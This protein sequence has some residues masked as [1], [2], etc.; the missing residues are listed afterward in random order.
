MS[1]TSSWVG[2]PHD[3]DVAIVGG[4]FAGTCAAATLS[5]LGLSVTLVELEPTPRDRFR[6]EKIS[7]DQLDALDRLGLLHA[8]RGA[9]TVARQ[10]FNIRGA[11]VIDRP[12]VEDHGLRYADML[13]ILHGQLPAEV[14]RVVGRVCAIDTS[15]DRQS[16][17]L[18]DG[19]RLSAR[20]VVLATGHA[21]GVREL[22]G[23]EL[24][25]VHS[26]PTVS[27]AFSLHAG[28]AGF[29]FPSIS[30]YGERTGDGVDYTSIFPI[31]DSMRV[32][33]F[34]FSSLSDPRVAAFKRDPMAALLS[35][36]PGL[37]PWLAGSEAVGR[38]EFFLLA[39]AKCER[40]VQPGVVLIG[41]AFRTACPGVGDGLNCVLQDVLALAPQVERWMRTPGMGANKIAAFYA[42]PVKQAQDRSAHQRAFQRRH[43]VLSTGLGN[44]VRRGVHFSRRRLADRLRLG[45]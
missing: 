4:G 1:N 5:R 33:V 11:A 38:T 21:R 41:D 34:T 29:R 28:P 14:R 9:S 24:K 22:L 18:T 10:A 19:R 27:V 39:L 44:R 30:A 45:A 31:G 35:L 40:V 26:A 37:A 3:C 20:L 16:V 23:I 8:I 6:V 2:G 7:A 36:Q 43:S 15:N 42:D 32:N 17:G 12:R 13:T 25:P